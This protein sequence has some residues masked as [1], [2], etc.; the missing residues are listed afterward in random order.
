MDKAFRLGI[1]K[2]EA[3]RI[4]ARKIQ[5]EKM[6]GVFSPL[7][8]YP[9][10]S[11]TR[12][13]ISIANKGKRSGKDNYWFGKKRSEDQKAYI[14]KIK[15]LEGHW[16]GI[17]NPR[18]I[19]PL[20]G[21]KNGRWEGGITPIHAKIRNSNEYLEWKI[22]VFKRDNYTCQY[23]GNKPN[24][25]AHHV[26]NFSKHPDKR[27]DINNG[28]TLCKSCHN[29]TIK[30][31]FHSKFGTHNN[32]LEQVYEYFLGNSWCVSSSVLKYPISTV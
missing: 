17:N 31:S 23:C 6:S 11:D 26:E 15:T 19:N 16:K 27:F 24:L 21:E 32:T 4:R 7:Y 9:R 5:A 8:N 28:I 18:H 1:Q 25:E 20:T 30:G 3:T 29:P 13:K 2:S 12:K 22:S 14:S 10:T